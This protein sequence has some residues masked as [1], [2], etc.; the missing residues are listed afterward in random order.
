MLNYKTRIR[1]PFK[2]YCQ[3]KE[4]QFILDTDQ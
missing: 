1:L 4:T 3:F 2:Y